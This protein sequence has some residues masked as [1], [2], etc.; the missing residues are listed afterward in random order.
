MLVSLDPVRDTPEVLRGFSFERN[1]YSSRWMIAR[2]GNA[3]VNRVAR[4]LGISYEGEMAGSL[5]HT[6]ALVLLD[7]RG[8]EVARTDKLDVPS[9]EFMSAVREAIA[10]DART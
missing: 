10:A 7:S 3:D 1:I 5:N 4:A 2:T 9:A 6:P 8:H